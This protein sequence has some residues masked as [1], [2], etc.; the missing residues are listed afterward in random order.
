MN[1]TAIKKLEIVK[2]LS[3]VPNSSL[4]KIK[5]FIE[6]I[7]EASNSTLKNNRSLKG[8]WKDKGFEK[9]DNLDDEIKKARKQIAD[10]IL[11]KEL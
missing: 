10:S 3:Q 7:L 1:T 6:S 11:K 2:E 4:D 9:I 8:I 5:I